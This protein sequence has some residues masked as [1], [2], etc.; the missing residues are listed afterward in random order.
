[1]K[2]LMSLAAMIVSLGQQLQMKTGRCLSAAFRIEP[3]V[4]TFPVAAIFA[5]SLWQCSD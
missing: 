3:D 4:T 2:L 1:M 5:S